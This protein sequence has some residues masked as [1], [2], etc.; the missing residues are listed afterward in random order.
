MWHGQKEAK[1]WSN[2]SVMMVMVMSAAAMACVGVRLGGG[3]MD[4]GG[5]RTVASQFIS[6]KKKS[7]SFWLEF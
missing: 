4:R 7:K 1:F 6:G 2:N 3:A 5:L